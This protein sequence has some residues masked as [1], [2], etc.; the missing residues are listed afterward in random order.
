MPDRA[1]GL[2]GGVGSIGTGDYAYNLPQSPLGGF[3]P[4][5]MVWIAW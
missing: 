4:S 2:L 3:H 5:S 1:G